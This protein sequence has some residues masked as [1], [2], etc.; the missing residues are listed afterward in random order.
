MGFQEGAY[1]IEGPSVLQS[2]KPTLISGSA[3]FNHPG[4]VDS[5]AEPRPRPS[6]RP[7]PKSAPVSASWLSDSA[8][9]VPAHTMVL[10]ARGALQ[11]QARY[12]HG[13]RFRFLLGWSTGLILCALSLCFRQLC[14]LVPRFRSGPIFLIVF[15]CS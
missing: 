12:F 5:S 3:I 2:Q 15:L 9:R 10:V 8:C 7:A 1:R 13:V 6:P 4:G 14:V 11:M